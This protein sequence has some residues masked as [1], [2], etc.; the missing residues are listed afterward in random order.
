MQLRAAMLFHSVRLGRAD[1]VALRDAT[2]ADVRA[3]GG[4]GCDLVGSLC[5][6]WMRMTCGGPLC[7][8]FDPSHSVPAIALDQG[9]AICIGVGAY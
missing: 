9:P 4:H 7:R 3:V 8:P 5:C 1:Y 6:R 2:V